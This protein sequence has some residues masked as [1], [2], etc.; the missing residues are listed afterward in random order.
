MTPPS[1]L[2]WIWGT[3]P[4]L[5]RE[6]IGGNNSNPSCEPPATR[7]STHFEKVRE[8]FSE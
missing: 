2:C 8:T 6:N 5:S 7:M 1:A 3:V 4:F